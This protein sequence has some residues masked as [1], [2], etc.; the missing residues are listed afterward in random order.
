[1]SPLF[2]KDY[3]KWVKENFDGDVEIEANT[4]LTQNKKGSPVSPV[5]PDKSGDSGATGEPPGVSVDNQSTEKPLALTAVAGKDGRKVVVSVY[6]VGDVE[7]VEGDKVVRRSKLRFVLKYKDIT[8]E[9][10]SQSRDLNV[11]CGLMIKE[12]AKATHY[13]RTV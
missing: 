8:K 1:M 7:K 3:W 6:K 4:S 12:V 13:S 10:V 9:C 2:P 11:D 5:S